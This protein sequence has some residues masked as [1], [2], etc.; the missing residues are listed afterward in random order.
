MLTLTD[1]LFPRR[2]PVCDRPVPVRDKEICKECRGRLIY[3]R[4][5]YCMRCGKPLGMRCGKPLG[6]GPDAGGTEFC[7]DCSHKRHVYDRGVCLY[8]YDSIRR[9]VYRFKYGGRREYASFLGK[10][11]AEVLGEVLR[12]WKPDALV[13]VPLHPARLRKRGYN[14]ALLLARELGKQLKIPVEEHW[15]YR[16]KNTEPLKLLDGR[17]RQN[18]LKKAFNIVQN[19][20]KLRTIIIIDDIYTTG[21]TVDEIAVICRQNGV[22]RIYFAALSVG[23]GL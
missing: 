2:C 20:V 10:E 19:E 22:E 8:R 11:M 13:P 5:P 21:S 7:F 4:E 1:L 17:E 16:V 12:S 14:Q 15:L 18:N 23:S 6:M 9:T 3:I